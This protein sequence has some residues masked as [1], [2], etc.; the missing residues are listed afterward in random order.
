MDF[1]DRVLTAASKSSSGFS[2]AIR[3]ALSLGKRT[4][5]KYHNKAAE[6][7]IYRI[8][9]GM[10]LPYLLLCCAFLT[11]KHI[12][13]H[14]RHKLEY[15]KRNKWDESSIAAARDIVQDEFDRS[16]WLQD[17]EGDL[18]TKANKN[19]AAVCC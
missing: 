14:P 5:D 10:F 11:V 8:A 6:S 1:I 18:A 9:M 3:A 17:F 12:V 2:L 19:A 13:L 16:Y 15:F 4:L 7:D